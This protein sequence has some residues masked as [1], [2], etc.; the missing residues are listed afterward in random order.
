MHVTKPGGKRI[1]NIFLMKSL[2]KTSTYIA[3]K[4]VLKGS[5]NRNVH[6]EVCGLGQMLSQWSTVFNL[7]LRARQTVKLWSNTHRSSLTVLW[8]GDILPD[9]CLHSHQWTIP[10]IQLWG[11]IITVWMGNDGPAN[12]VN[13]TQKRVRQR[14]EIRRKSNEVFVTVGQKQLSPLHNMSESVCL[15]VH[16][17]LQR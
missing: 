9:H 15:G 8:Q 11:L 6:A 13:G 16:H 17:V 7:H 4:M 1:I 2:S 5:S 3:V 12:Y 14:E 10:H